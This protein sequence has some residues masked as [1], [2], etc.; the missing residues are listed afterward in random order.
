MLIR[1]IPSMC[2][3]PR[4]RIQRFSRVAS[5]IHER[6]RVRQKPDFKKVCSR[7]LLPHSRLLRLL[8][9]S[10]LICCEYP[11]YGQQIITPGLIIRSANQVSNTLDSLGTAYLENGEAVRGY[12]RLL[13][14]GT[15]KATSARL[16]DAYSSS[17]NVPLQKMDRSLS[18]PLEHLSTI[19]Q[20]LN[21]VNELDGS[22]WTDLILKVQEVAHETL[23]SLP[24]ADKPPVL[25]GVAIP[26]VLVPMYLDKEELVIFGYHLVDSDMSPVVTVAGIPVPR[27]SVTADFTKIVV[28]LPQAAI[29]NA[30]YL[31]TPCEP[32]KSFELL[33]HV[34][35][36]SKPFWSVFSF[37]RETEL[38]LKTRAPSPRF[39]FVL[40]L[41]G[42]PKV[43]TAQTIP[44]VT[45]SP[46]V[47]VNCEQTSTTVVQW[48]APPDTKVTQ[49]PQPRWV[50]T[51]NVRNA[52]QS[53]S[54][55]GTS[56]VAYGSISGNDKQCA[57]F[58]ICNCPGGGHGRLILEGFYS[59]DNLSRSL[60]F[61]QTSKVGERTQIKIPSRSDWT[62]S[63]LVIHIARKDCREELD[64]LEL[65][66][67]DLAGDRSIPSIKGLFRVQTIDGVI[68]LQVEANISPQ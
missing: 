27:A 42:V 23:D 35:F 53:I 38:S 17:L 1:P 18:T 57:I 52:T 31:N 5:A 64:R 66:S 58:N 10:V 37:R 7:V 9:L 2:Q 44:L 3:L 61:Q 14:A 11:A 22:Q 51:N 20:T 45:S 43:Q 32:L 24:S 47:Q 29:H 36:L 62:L 59:P 8:C 56:Y 16:S 46:Y 40:E 67:N 21:G 4:I 39:D 28:R 6:L 54:G 63:H 49:P 13:L 55:G 65:N 60:N 15:L 41:T 19:L 48:Q 25:F 68:T 34:S 33:V 50:E 12:Q 30:G 26:G